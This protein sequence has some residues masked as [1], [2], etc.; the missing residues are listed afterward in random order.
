MLPLP[1]QHRN[2]TL[3]ATSIRFPRDLDAR[4][5]WMPPASHARRGRSIQVTRYLIQP[6]A[7]QQLPCFDITRAALARALRRAEPDLKA[8][9][10][11]GSNGKGGFLLD[12]PENA[13]T[14]QAVAAFLADLDTLAA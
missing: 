13:R 4:K 11:L 9:V 2:L 6:V 8:L 14:E 5:P 1:C 3:S 12:V 7:G 10:D